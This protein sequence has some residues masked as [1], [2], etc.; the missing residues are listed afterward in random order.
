M[1]SRPFR[2][3][4]F[5]LVWL[6]L[7]APHAARAATY[8]VATNGTEQGDGSDTRPW[9]T[10]EFAL[11]RVGG[12]NTVIVKPGNYSG[13]WRLSSAFSGSQAQPTVVKSEQKWKARLIGSFSH[14]IYAADRTHWIVIDGFEI[15]GAL[16]DGVKLSGDDCTVRNCWI[17]NNAQMGCSAHGHERN[18]FES[19][20]IEFNGQNIQLHHGIYADGKGLIVRNNVVRNNAAYG[21]HLYPAVSEATICNNLV[22]GHSHKAGILIQCPPG[23]G[24]NRIVNNTSVNNR[25]ALD[26]RNGNGEIVAN[27]I[28]TAP[29]GDPIVFDAQTANIVSDYNLCWPASAHNGSHGIAADPKFVDADHQCFW[30]SGASPAIGHA[31]RDYRPET[32][33]WGRPNPAFDMGCFTYQPTLA[34]ASARAGWYYGLPYRFEPEDGKDAPDFWSEP[35]H[36]R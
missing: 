13:G 31:G 22:T 2:V 17:H 16:Y 19:N 35:G 14:G 24:R 4:G 25:A 11:G 1:L 10:V 28:L 26:I 34:L 21:L 8:Y 32:D 33:F 29:S 30:L 9:P 18:A 3:R 20:L 6:L 23:G 36:D 15:A 12:G 27:N 7:C 5:A